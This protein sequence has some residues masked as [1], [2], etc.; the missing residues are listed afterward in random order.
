MNYFKVF[1]LLFTI[2]IY[3]QEK[4][5]LDENFRSINK[6]EYSKRCKK[7]FFKCLEYKSDSLS[8]N[9]IL[10]R[11][12]F[13]K[14]SDTSYHQIRNLLIRDSKTSIDS[15]SI[16]IVKYYDSL[17]NFQS[18]YKKHLKHIEPK[19]DS[20]GNEL[21]IHQHEFNMD[22]YKKNKANYVKERKK[23]IKKFEK[24]ENVRVFHMYKH[25]ENVANTYEDF[26]WIDDRG[27]FENT[28]F[29]ILFNYSSVL[30]KPNGDYFLIGGHF[31][32]KDLKSLI[33]KQN[34][35]SFRLDWEKTYSSD[36]LNGKGIFKMPESF[37][38]TKHCF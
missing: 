19:T 16:I 36:A 10:F 20:L 11:Y 34:W 17:I 3:S 22:I 32:D 24:Y 37:Y 25:E 6:L 4:I 5:Y 21:P 18:I 26:D 9:K 8:I 23:C 30:I 15:N 35:E 28:F 1:F 38:H 12:R 27:T 31:P 33:K 2:S 7:N 29:Q 14:I 13:G